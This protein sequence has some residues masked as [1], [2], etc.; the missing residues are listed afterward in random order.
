[1]DK[2]VLSAL[3]CLVSMNHV[4]SP[5]AESG[6]PL[7]PADL[8][9]AQRAGLAAGVLL[10]HAVLAWLVWHSPAPA[11]VEAALPVITAT[12]VTEATREVAVPASSL[13]APAAPVPVPAPA[14]AW[15][16]A[17]RP[18]QAA[19]APAVLSSPRP[20]MAGDAQAVVPP[21]PQL[22]SPG[23]AAPAPAASPAPLT[24]PPAPAPSIQVQPSGEAP[25]P[26]PKELP[27]ASVRYLV[28]PPQIYPRASLDLGESGLVV[29][30]VLVDEEGRPKDV[31]LVKSSGFSRLDRQ[32]VQNMKG[33]RFQPHVEAGVPRAVWVPAEIVFNLE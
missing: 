3:S 18:P 28:E 25:R 11:K 2:I 5:R 1:M 12:L 32:A 29:L 24:T 8:S 19:P 10:I 31:Q 23:S 30:R 27:M 33:A 16:S 13:V 9:T 15:P 6:L 26:A 21:A 17:A 7:V 14:A 4:L 22:V 20:A